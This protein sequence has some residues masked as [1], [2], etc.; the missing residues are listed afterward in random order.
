MENM[1]RNFHCSL[2][3]S[4]FSPESL[5][6][7]NKS[8]NAISVKNFWHNWIKEFYAATPRGE[9]ADDKGL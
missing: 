2:S 3:Q 9:A 5:F 6:L 7:M 4:V 1:G 8:A